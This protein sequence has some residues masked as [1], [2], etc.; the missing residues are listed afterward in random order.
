MR[1]LN[2]LCTLLGLLLALECAAKDIVINPELGKLVLDEQLSYLHDQQQTLDLSQLVGSDSESLNW[3]AG[4]QRAGAL[5]MAPGLYW[6]KGQLR[7]DSEQTIDLVL[8]TEYPSIKVADLYLIKDNEIETLYANA[9]LD[10][11]FT[12]RPIPH[13]TL[14]NPI[15][16]TPH[17]S[18]TLIWRIDSEPLFQFKATIWQP[19]LFIDRDQHRQL[20]Y[21]LL[22]GCLIVMTL[23]NLFLFFACRQRS[24]FYYVLYVSSATYL[25]AADQGH[26]YQYLV[27]DS[28]W[29]KL[30]IYA[31]MYI[32]NFNMFAQFSIHFLNLKKY[33]PRLLLGIR[34]LAILSSLIA[35][36]VLTTGYL[37]LIFIGLASMSLL[38]AAALAAGII[39]RRAGVISAGHFI[40]AM[41]IQV[42]T[43][44]ASN[45]TTLG[46]L[47][48]S[49]YQKVYPL[50]VLR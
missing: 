37:P 6:F 12:N 20:F 50:L 21:G 47:S 7:N 42:F 34:S 28:N 29:E 8:Q 2:Y 14:I 49:G 32:V 5:I 22:Y 17:S 41:M 23:Y 15:S 25:I 45:M 27:T 26:A 11:A 44:I 10:D 9:G 4:T 39:V 33:A 3:Q 35:F 43:L 19:Q 38:F 48:I 31:F 36:G 1:T 18:I 30:A 24:Y 16:L 13:R 40:I 46:I